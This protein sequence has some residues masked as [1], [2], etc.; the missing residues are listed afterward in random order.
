[1]FFSV[2]N[3]FFSV[4]NVFFG[5]ERVFLVSNMFFRFPT[6]SFG[7]QRV[8]SVSNVLFLVSNTFLWFPMRFFQFSMCFYLFIDVSYPFFNMFSHFP[9]FF[10]LTHISGRC[11]LWQRWVSSHL[12]GLEMWC[13]FQPLQSLPAEGGSCD[14]LV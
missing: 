9:M 14:P 12:G 10:F 1:M 6:C 7:F 11:H 5:F 8:F 2:S 3:M 13:S 4:S